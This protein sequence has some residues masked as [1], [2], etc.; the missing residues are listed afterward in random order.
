MVD[1]VSKAGE[2]EAGFELAGEGRPDVGGGGGE[3][4]EDGDGWGGHGGGLFWCWYFM[5][6]PCVYHGWL[7][8]HGIEWNLC[9]APFNVTVLGTSYGSASRAVQATDTEGRSP[10][11]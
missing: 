3:T 2:A 1:F 5:D 8:V 4:A 7:G 11:F 10:G 6:G 9:E